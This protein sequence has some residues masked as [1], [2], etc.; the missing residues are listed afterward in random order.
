[1]VEMDIL[2]LDIRLSLVVSFIS[3]ISNQSRL[4]ENNNKKVEQVESN[5]TGMQN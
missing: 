5:K 2:S 1:M 4:R 3:D